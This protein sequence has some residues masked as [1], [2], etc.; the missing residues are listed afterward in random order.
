MSGCGSGEG[1]KYPHDFPGHWVKQ[2]Y[3]PPEVRG[4][5]YYKPSEMGHEDVI[6]KN[7]LVREGRKP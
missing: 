2:E 7:H 3:M 4:R 1:Y 6:R 5:K